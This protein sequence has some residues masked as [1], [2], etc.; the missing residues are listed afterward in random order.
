MAAGSSNERSLE[1]TPTWAVALVCTV[2]VIISVIIE[3]GI[4][5]VGKWFQKKQKKAMLEALEK[6]KAEL[7]LLGFLSLLLTVGTSYVAK[8]CVPEKIGYKML[9]CKAKHYNAGHEGK[10]GGDEDGGGGDEGEHRR[11]LLNVAGDMI[12]R[13]VLAASSK[14]GGSCSKVLGRNVGP[15]LL[16]LDIIS[17]PNIGPEN[18][19]DFSEMKKWQ[20]WEAETTSLEY[21]FTNDP[22]RF[23]FAHQTSFVK[24]HTGL[25]TKPGIRW[26]A[27]FAPSTKFDFHKYIKRSM[28]DDFKSVLGIRVACT[29]LSL[30]RPVSVIMEMAQQ[31]QDKATIVRGAPV[32]EPSNKFF[33]FNS[34]RLVLFLI[35]FTLFQNAFQMAFFLWTVYEF[36]IHSCYH[37]SITQIGVRVGL[38]VLLHI[39]CSYITFPL[40]ALVT[41]MGSHMKK[42]IF[43]EQ[44]SKALKK[45]QKAAKD[46]KKLRE[47]SGRGVVDGSISG[48]ENTPSRGSSPVYLLHNQ[49]QRSSTAESEIDIPSSPRGYHSETEVSDI[50]SSDLH[51]SHFLYAD[52]AILLCDWDVENAR[53]IVRM[54]RV[55]Q[56]AS[57]L[58]INLIKSKLI[59]VGVAFERVQEVA[60]MLGCNALKLPFIYLGVPVGCNM[61]RIM[62][63]KPMVDKFVMKLSNWK[64]KLLSF[65]GRLTLVKAVLGGLA[66]YYMSIYKAPV[67]VLKV[68]EA[69]RA[70]FFWGAEVGE[71]KIQWV[72]WN[73]VMQS[74][75]NGGLGV[76]SL[77]AFN[78]A[79]LFKWKW[80]YRCNPD[81]MWVR[82]L[83]AIHGYSGRRRMSRGGMSLWVNIGRMA[84]RLKDNGVDLEEFARIK[85][86]NGLHTRFWID[87][88]VGDQLLRDQFPR[89]FM[90][91]GEPAVKIADRSSRELVL[92]GLLRAPRAGVATEQLEELV[93]KLHS[94]TFSDASD[95]WI[96]E[97]ESSREFSVS[98]VRLYLDSVML[99]SFGGPTRWNVLVPRKINILLWRIVNDRIPT[100][101]NLRDKGIEL[102]SV[103]CPVCEEVGES[104]AHLFLACA[105]LVGLWRKVTLW[106]GVI[107]PDLVSI[108]KLVCW[109]ET[110]RMD[111][112]T[113]R[114]FNAVVL[115]TFWVIWNFRN[116]LLFGKNKIR[117]DELFDE[118]R[119]RSYFWINNRRH[120]CKMSWDRWL[121]HPNM[122]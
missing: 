84:E 108:N 95:S 63:W 71:R 44:T 80:R 55:F 40:Y 70:R 6:I 107:P 15:R 20:A 14:D 4:H 102:H 72:A 26:V 27:H 21:E 122:A 24:R 16:D 83:D 10:G 68:L 5:S 7:M 98:S 33:W 23:R 57:G 101:L 97:L 17:V 19:A 90:F 35:H 62:S 51:V 53:R 92:S 121:S 65:G 77:S 22:A 48:M 3:H 120:K 42:S 59:G 100:R 13:R 76:G 12:F 91:D 103:L 45:W 116:N 104:S 54:L 61:N 66:I 89:V 56:L 117:K 30:I 2:F 41:Q 1:Q 9:P 34:P 99:G 37:E 28:E 113:G 58:K 87:K 115:I 78:K 50:G 111:V 112:E 29:Y 47:L 110:V 64:A 106:W 105:D 93:R 60:A 74:K 94:Y 8:I 38:G 82:V 52:D 86:G 79:L 88:W 96:W 85:V 43:E 75:V 49:N 67:A 36:G 114:S 81:A 118:I 25:S 109:S 46:K 32:V 31:I 39:M 11:K 73:K 119:S 18:L 69:I